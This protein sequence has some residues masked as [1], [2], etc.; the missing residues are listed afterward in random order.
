[1]T[2]QQYLFMQLINEISKPK[3]HVT[4][5]PHQGVRAYQNASFPLNAFFDKRSEQFACAISLLAVA[6]CPHSLLFSLRERQLQH[7][8]Y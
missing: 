1:M 2:C 7:E 8:L 3:Q 6:R 5:T 4:N